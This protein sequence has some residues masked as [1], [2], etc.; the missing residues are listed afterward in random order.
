MIIAAFVR[1][2][3][4]AAAL[5]STPVLAQ[6]PD[7]PKPSPAVLFR[8]QCGTCHVL[9]PADGPRQGP[10]LAGVIGRKPGT[11]EGFHYTGDF[12]HAGFTWDTAHLDAYL[13]NPQAL[14]PGSAMAY[15]QAN[16]E[17]RR[18]IITYLEGQR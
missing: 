4:V 17:T 6:L 2:T 8:T 3:V 7:L 13:T 10:P 16:P 18:T 11:V 1:V 5:T 14:I 9:N 15:S 12:A